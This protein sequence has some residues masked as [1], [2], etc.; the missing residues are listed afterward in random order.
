MLQTWLAESKRKEGAKIKK[1][2]LEQSNKEK[3]EQNMQLLQPGMTEGRTG[4]GA[5]IMKLHLSGEKWRRKSRGCN[6]SRQ[7]WQRA[8]WRKAP[9][10]KGASGAEQEGEDGEVAPAALDRAG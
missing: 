10:P 3:M 1:L 6:N 4:E 9:R 7:D 2:F 5:K 8:R